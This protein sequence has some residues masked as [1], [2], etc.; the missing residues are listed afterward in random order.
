MS[1]KIKQKTLAGCFTLLVEVLF[2]SMINF[3]SSYKMWAIVSLLQLILNLFIIWNMSNTKKISF[4]SFFVILTAIFHC[5]HVYILG[6]NISG[7]LNL[8]FSNYGSQHAQ[9]GAFR[10]YLY[11]QILI[12]FGILICNEFSKNKSN[13]CNVDMRKSSKILILLGFIPRL[14]VDIIRLIR[15]LAMGYV[16]VYS[17]YTPQIINTFAFFFD[18]GVIIALLQYKQS[19]KGKL[20]FIGILFYKCLSMITGSRQENVGFLFIWLF[21]YFFL[22]RKV[23]IRSVLKFLC[24]FIVGLILIGTIGK[25]RGNGDFSLNTMMSFIDDTKIT[26]ILGN[27]LGEFGSAFSSLVVPFQQ[28]PSKVNFGFGKSYIVGLLSIIPLLVSK[29]P[30]LA[31]QTTYVSLYKGTTFFGGSML[32]ESYYNFG[33]FGLIILFIVGYIIKKTDIQM[34]KKVFHNYCTLDYIMA[35]VLAVTMLIFIRGYFTDM[36]QKTVWI[37]IVLTIINKIDCISQ[38]DKY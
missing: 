38:N 3:D 26:N 23:N 12:T 19:K 17:L 18:I 6:F 37:Y 10:Y 14:Y 25:T 28:S 32:G 8:N 21:I 7:E 2:I 35:F 29:F 36:V 22:I 33:W 1:F 20:L 4:I 31:N 15:G 27:F 24:I 9:I 5:G 13:S 30:A 34:T 16:G 11:S